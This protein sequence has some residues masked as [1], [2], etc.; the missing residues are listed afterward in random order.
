[1]TEL[2]PRSVLFGNPERSSASISPD[3]QRLAYLAPADGVMNVWVGTVD[4]RTS[5][6]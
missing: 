2:I 3:G 1:M 5:S 4:G 6:R